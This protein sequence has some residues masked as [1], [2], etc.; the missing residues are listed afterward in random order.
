MKKYTLRCEE[1]RIRKGTDAQKVKSELDALKRLKTVLRWIKE[2]THL[3]VG[4]SHNQ[5]SHF[6]WENNLI[7]IN[8]RLTCWNK[9]FILLH[10]IG[11]HLV[12]KNSKNKNRFS[13]GYGAQTISNH[14]NRHKID[15]LEEEFEAWHLGWN[16]GNKINAIHESHK[17][18]WDKTKYYH[19]N[20]YIKWSIDPAF[21][22]INTFN[23]LS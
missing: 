16:I 19:I 15:I 2:D 11:H 14:H 20:S 21:K 3:S 9:L 8:T 18:A 5:T 23:T 6:Q 22:T 1:K 10:E 4:F 7:V 13:Y 12:S 17:P